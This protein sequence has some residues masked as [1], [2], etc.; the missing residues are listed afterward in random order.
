MSIVRT[1][2]HWIE[3]GKIGAVSGE[4]SQKVSED[5]IEKR[6]IFTAKTKRSKKDTGC[7]FSVILTFLDSLEKVKMRKANHWKRWFC[8]TW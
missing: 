3:T 1:N 7:E 2:Y 4:T 8:F 6:E 5:F